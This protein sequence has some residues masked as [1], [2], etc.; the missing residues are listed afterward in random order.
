MT[1]ETDG[2]RSNSSLLDLTREEYFAERRLLI[3]ARQRSY[4]RAEQMVVGGATGALLLSITFLEK[5][6]PSKTVDKP[7]FLILSWAALLCCLTASLL[8]QH[9]SGRAFDCEMSRLDAMANQEKLLPSNRWA[10][11]NRVADMVAAILLV[12]GI[13]FL[14]VFAYLNAPFNL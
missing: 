8:G 6:V 9:S 11:C 7:V 14:A 1:N 5:L 10:T 4:Q 13:G 2:D 12:L 3:D